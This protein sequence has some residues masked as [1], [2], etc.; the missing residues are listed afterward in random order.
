MFRVIAFDSRQPDARIGKGTIYVNDQKSAEGRI[1][2]T[3]IKRIFIEL[4][5]MNPAS[6]AIAEKS[7]AVVRNTKAI[8]D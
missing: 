1:G 6:E 8:A 5:D 7:L 4:K 2:H 3:Q